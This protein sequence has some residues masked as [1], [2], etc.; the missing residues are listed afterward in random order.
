MRCSSCLLVM[1]FLG[2]S[3]RLVGADDFKPEAGFHLLLGKSLDGW[4]TKSGDTALD[5]KA[6][7]YKGRFKLMDG[8]LTIDPTVK[9]DVI[10]VTAKELKDVH[11]KFD[12]KPDAKCNNDL[13]L[14]GM[15]FD[16]IP[17]SFKNIKLDDW[18]ELE[19]VAQDGKAEV[20]INGESV[21]KQNL[22]TPAS[23][24]G[25]RAEFGGLQVRRLRVKEL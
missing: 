4:K 3:T 24:F 21:R 16:I 14:R 2:T 10:I 20:K 25:I 12:F 13:F 8:V 15:K 5:G 1:L 6:E 9:G 22:K 17:K 23:P 7:A 18:N 19:I 11:I